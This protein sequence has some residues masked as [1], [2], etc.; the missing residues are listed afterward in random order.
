M[1]E[2]KNGK[3]LI[4]SGFSGGS[5]KTHLARKVLGIL[6][7]GPYSFSISYTTRPPREGEKDGE[8]YHFVGVEEFK[9]LIEKDL[10]FEWNSPREGIYYGTPMFD[11]DG[12]EKFVM[13]IDCFG[14]QNIFERVKKN[15]YE[16]NFYSV[17]LL[18]N[19]FTRLTWMR[20]RD[21]TAEIE[22]FSRR[23]ALAEKNERPFFE[24]KENLFLFNKILHGY[25]KEASMD[26]DFLANEIANEIRPHFIL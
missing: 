22:E 8:D 25:G 5:G 2:S 9:N 12:D 3:H 10:F 14:V 21:P 13:D 18:P 26:V 15:K 11:V 6:A 19:A 23:A 4:V 1:K 24:K 16:N 17:A 7:G 20:K